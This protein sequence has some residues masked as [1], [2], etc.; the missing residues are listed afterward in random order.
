[1]RTDG[2]Q[3]RHQRL[4]FFHFSPLSTSQGDIKDL[5]KQGQVPAKASTAFKAAASNYMSYIMAIQ[6]GASFGVELVL[7]NM[8]ASYFHDEFGANVTKAGQIALL[9]GVRTH[10]PLPSFPPSLPA[11]SSER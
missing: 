10:T 5:I 4:T 3:Q 7:F 6:Y 1:M 11:A 2:C 9:C 8:A